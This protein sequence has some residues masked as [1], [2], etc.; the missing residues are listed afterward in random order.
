MTP[1]HR[2]SIG[3][4]LEFAQVLIEHGADV[5]AKDESKSSPLHLALRGGHV[6]FAQV[7]VEHGADVNAQ[8]SQVDAGA[9]SVR[10][11]TRRSGSGAP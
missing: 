6:G 5:N 9:S 2:A 3:G 11:R 10:R 8:D 1:L 7:L 4:H